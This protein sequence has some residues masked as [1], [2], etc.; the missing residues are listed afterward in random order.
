LLFVLMPG[1]GPTLSAPFGIPDDDP[2]WQ[3][4]R[5]IAYWSSLALLPLLGGVLVGSAATERV[6]ATLA[7]AALLLACV[8]MSYPNSLLVPVFGLVPA[9]FYGLITRVVRWRAKRGSLA[10]G[11]LGALVGSCVAYVLGGCV[12]A[13]AM[14]VL[15][16]LTGNQ[17]AALVFQVALVAGL[18]VAGAVVGA[19]V[20][21]RPSRKASPAP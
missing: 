4:V 12:G 7:G 2:D 11:L 14:G 6:W 5:P 8:A 3:T 1:L 19:W 18:P 13:A 21:M 16:R 20:G 10:D 15:T 17:G 9:C